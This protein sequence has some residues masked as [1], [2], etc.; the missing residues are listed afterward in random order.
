[1]AGTIYDRI[2]QRRIEVGLDADTVAKRLGIS[3][4]TYYRYE[5]K[6]IK[7]MPITI[8]KPLANIL[9]TTPEYLMGWDELPLNPDGDEAEV[10][11]STKGVEEVTN[12]KLYVTIPIYS[13][14]KA[15]L[16]LTDPRNIVGHTEILPEIATTGKYFAFQVSDN[17]MAPCILPNDVVIIKQ[18]T[19]IEN[20]QIG[21]VSVATE[22]P[23]IKEI[24][25]GPAGITLIGWNVATYQPHFYSNEDVKTLP[26]HILGRVIEVRRKL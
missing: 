14:K 1:M 12:K 26:V 17:T 10:L 9:D 23:T 11:L 4:A 8:L 5:S 21:F 19:T 25:I 2:K 20:K 22:A 7:K 16:E 24:Q 3:R 18:Q 15:D 13:Y 6:K